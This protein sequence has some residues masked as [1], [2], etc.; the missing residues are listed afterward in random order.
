VLVVLD[1]KTAPGGKVPVVVKRKTPWFCA[2]P[3]DYLKSTYI[4]GK[5]R[6]ER[7]DVDG[8]GNTRQRITSVASTSN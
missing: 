2:F 8:T 6:T 3:N 1:P 5:Y 4:Y 7:I